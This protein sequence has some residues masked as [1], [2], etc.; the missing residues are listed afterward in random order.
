MLKPIKGDAGA[1]TDDPDR[2]LTQAERE[3]AILEVF[4]A[5]G[6]FFP[7]QPAV[8]EEFSILCRK[9]APEWIDYGAAAEMIK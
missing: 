6:C 3:A 2:A 9:I 7:A 8:L 1:M 4:Q 5:G